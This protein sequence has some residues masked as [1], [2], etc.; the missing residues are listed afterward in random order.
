M[1][2]LKS[3]ERNNRPNSKTAPSNRCVPV[4]PDWKSHLVFWSVAAVGLWLDIWTKRAIFSWLEGKP[5]N[6]VSVING[7]LQLVRVVNPG[8]AF[9][10]VAGHLNLLI[11]VSFLALIVILIIFFL[12]G[13]ERKLVH[14]ALALFIAGICGNLYDRIFNDGLVR[15]FI[16][17]VYWPGIH[18]PAFNVAD[19]L[20][21]IGVVLLMI[22]TFTSPKRA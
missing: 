4:M 9:G 5:G 11:A 15:D 10:I 12:S 7:F 20:L 17:V 3:E 16:D 8:A 1:I 19:S 18:W 6:S 21:C 22:S 14:I 2:Q 13:A